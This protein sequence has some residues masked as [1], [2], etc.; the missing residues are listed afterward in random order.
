MVLAPATHVAYTHHQNASVKQFVILFNATYTNVVTYIY[1]K[2]AHLVDLQYY[3][4]RYFH[5]D[6]CSTPGMYTFFK[7]LRTTSKF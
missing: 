5:V 6:A 3:I 2:T 4:A 1:T 7:N